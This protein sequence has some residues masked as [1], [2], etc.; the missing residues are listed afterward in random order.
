ME[1]FWQDRVTVLLVSHSMELIRLNCHKTI[2]MERGR[3]R[4]IG[5]TDDV[6][7]EYLRDSDPNQISHSATT[8]V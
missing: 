1:E 2:W 7:D 4:K 3:I 6:V 5:A 8:Q